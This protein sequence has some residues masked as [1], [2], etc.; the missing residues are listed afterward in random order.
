MINDI[1]VNDNRIFLGVNFYINP[2]LKQNNVHL[3]HEK[4]YSHIYHSSNL[5]D[6]AGWFLRL[7]PSE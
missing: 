6:S 2:Q 4:F 5:D 1:L 3:V 7:H